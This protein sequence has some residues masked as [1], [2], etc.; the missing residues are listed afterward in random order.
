MACKRKSNAGTSS[1]S[2][3]KSKNPRQTKKARVEEELKNPRQTN[4]TR[5]EEGLATSVE[6][7]TSPL[8]K[9]VTQ[10]LA[11]ADEDGEESRFIGKPME[12]K[13][14]RKQ[15]PK[16]YVGEVDQDVKSKSI[17]VSNCYCDTKYLLP[18]STFVNLRTGYCSLSTYCHD[19]VTPTQRLKL[20]IIGLIDRDRYSDRDLEAARQEV[21]EGRTNNKYN[22]NNLDWATIIVVFCLTVAIGIALLPFQVPSIFGVLEMTCYGLEIK[23]RQVV[24]LRAMEWLEAF[25]NWHLP[26]KIQKLCRS[27]DGTNLRGDGSRATSMGRGTKEHELEV[28]GAICFVIQVCSRDVRV[29]FE[30]ASLITLA[31]MRNTGDDTLILGPIIN[32]VRFRIDEFQWRGTAYE[33]LLDTL[34]E[35]NSL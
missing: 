28:L 33:L 30:G 2:P 11:A 15:D 6:K 20:L 23:R 1:G 18:Y 32:D 22:N 21:A 29:V 16:R 3:P 35:D 4:K 27:N 26:P 7:A 10:E 9:P 17:P 13:D 5:V 8:R 19:A 25:Q 12:D 14:A 31:A 34:M 24:S